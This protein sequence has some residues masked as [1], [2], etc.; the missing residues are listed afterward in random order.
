MT[1]SWKQKIE[2]ALRGGMKY[3][4][5]LESGQYPTLSEDEFYG[6]PDNPF[7]G[8]LHFITSL[9]LDA[10][11]A[12]FQEGFRAGA[13][14]A[15]NGV[16]PREWKEVEGCPVEVQSYTDELFSLACGRAWEANEAGTSTTHIE[17]H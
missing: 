1:I 8:F 13:D 5:P 4:F 17:A 6:T 11:K 16:R 15:R 3:C 10:R 7:S 9:V 2:S 14:T 12:A